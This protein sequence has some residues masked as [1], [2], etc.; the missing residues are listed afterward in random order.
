MSKV[1]ADFGG[2]AIPRS[3]NGWRELWLKEDCGRSGSAS[4]SSSSA[5]VL[6]ANGSSLKWIAVTPPKW[7]TLAQLGAHFAANWPRYIVQFLALARGLLGRAQR[8][9]P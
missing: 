7:S 9:R 1:E 8:A 3:S 5:Y 6:F 2:S 4:A